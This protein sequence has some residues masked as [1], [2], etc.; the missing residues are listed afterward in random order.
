MQ[1]SLG[2]FHKAC[3]RVLCKI[4]NMGYL[5]GMISLIRQQGGQCESGQITTKRQHN[6]LFLCASINTAV[7]LAC[8]LVIW[9]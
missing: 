9:K 8:L 2:V 7:L 4:K 6:A 3:N 1:V 5:E